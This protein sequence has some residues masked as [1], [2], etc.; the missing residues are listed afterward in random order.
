MPETEETIADVC[1]ALRGRKRWQ[2]APDRRKRLQVYSESLS[3]RFVFIQH[4]FVKMRQAATEVVSQTKGT[5][6]AILDSEERL[7]F[8]ANSFW[9]FAY[10]MFDI[11]ANVINVVHRRC[12]DESRVS[13]KKAATDYEDL[14]ECQRGP[15]KKLPVNLL[16][17]IERVTAN[18]TFER[19]S[20]YRHCCLHRRAVWLGRGKAPRDLRGPY[21]PDSTAINQESDV[22]LV[23]D[24]PEE[25]GDPASK[26]N[27]NLSVECEKIGTFVKTELIAI[28]KIL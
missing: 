3:E 8:Y 1:K 26:P 9:A 28:L 19:L 27:R 16:R 10:S 14:R 17:R 25:M 20:Q 23:S 22:I 11:L 5:S 24:D 15:C 2:N 6:D 18:E 4:S 21:A 7:A 12:K 13:F